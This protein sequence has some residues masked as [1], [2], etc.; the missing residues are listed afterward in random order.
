MSNTEIITESEARTVDLQAHAETINQTLDLIVMH[1]DAFEESTLEPRLII[2]LEI[3]KAQEV[4]GMSDPGTR[5]Q[6]GINQHS[7]EAL[8]RRAMASNPLG[9]SG[10]LV[11]HI[12]RL[13][14][15]TAR[16]YASAFRSLGL[17]ADHATPS[18]IRAKIK[19]IRHHCG[20]N[21]LPMPTLAGLVKQAPKE[22]LP[23]KGPIDP[24]TVNLAHAPDPVELRV[25]DAREFST[26][27]IRE[28]DAN[29]KRGLLDDLPA[30]D[31]P[32]MLNFLTE[33]R[34]HV[35]TLLKSSK[36]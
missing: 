11:K 7:K 36:A 2:G 34:D 16:K 31:L 13:P 9:F 12:P 27:W 21:D 15:S 35:R 18:S 28:W 10:W 1:E 26:T 3:A 24:E 30:E 19:D 22:P 20:K 14:R 33:A 6:T 29:V 23:T 5:N 17:N 8:A 32:A 4:F 25:G